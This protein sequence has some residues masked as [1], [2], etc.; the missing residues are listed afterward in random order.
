MSSATTAHAPPPPPPHVTTRYSLGSS[1]TSQGSEAWKP[2]LLCPIA[3]VLL[4]GY[5][6]PELP[7]Y[8]ATMPWISARAVRL[9]SFPMKKD[10]FRWSVQQSLGQFSFRS[11]RR[12]GRRGHERSAPS[13]PGAS[14]TPRGP[15]SP[16]RRSWDPHPAGA[17]PW[18]PAGSKE[19]G[20]QRTPRMTAG[21]ATKPAA[22]MERDATSVKEGVPG[23]D[24]ASRADTQGR[25]GAGGGLL[26]RLPPLRSSPPER[27]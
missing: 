21:T 10:T 14:G 22:A 4:H 26:P 15:P 24:Q 27:A 2:I 20:S 11:A 18:T 9:G 7:R 6:E 3:P 16:G 1:S 5:P 12:E 25:P 13:R 17:Q 8:K 23:I 19:G